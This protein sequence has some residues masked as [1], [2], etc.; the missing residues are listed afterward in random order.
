MKVKKDKK[1]KGQKRKI[2]KEN[3]EKI[4]KTRKNYILGQD[5]RKIEKQAQQRHR[6]KTE[7]RMKDTEKKH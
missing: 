4:E 6:R 1:E 5:G 2:K 3:K 7:T